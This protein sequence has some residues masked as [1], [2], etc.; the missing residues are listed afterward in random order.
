MA[1]STTMDVLVGSQLNWL[2]DPATCSGCCPT[3]DGAGSISR[4]KISITY[5]KC[6]SEVGFFFCRYSMRIKFSSITSYYLWA[7]AELY[8]KDLHDSSPFIRRCVNF[9]M[10][11]DPVFLDQ[12][13]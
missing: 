6:D 7:G 9:P 5:I 4:E 11:N 10:T 2:P 12:V 8:I 3:V 1:R 13:H